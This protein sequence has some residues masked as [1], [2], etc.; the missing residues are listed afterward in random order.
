M[1]GEAKV[2]TGLLQ[3]RALE[4][5][6]AELGRLSDPDAVQR[7]AQTIAEYGSAALQHLLTLLDTPD[8]QLRGGLGQVARK[9]PR[10]QVVPALRGVVRDHGRSDQA[11][12]AAVTLLERFL[13][14]TIDNALIGNLGNPDVA[15]RQSLLELIAAMEEE[16]LSVVEYLEQLGQ[17][18]ADVVSMVLDALPAVDPSPHLATF[19]RMLA[20]GED[21]RVARRAVDELIKLRT[22]AAAR[23]LASLA[24]NLPPTLA[25]VAERGLRKLRFSGVDDA[26]D[27]D[28]TREPW[29]APELNWRALLSPVD[30]GGAQ[31]LWFVGQEEG[32]GKRTVFFTVLTQDPR[33]MVD[34]SGALQAAADRVPSRKRVGALHFIVGDGSAPGVTLLE[35]PL[36]LAYGTLRAALALN[37]AGG[38]ATPIGYRLFAPLVWLSEHAASQDSDEDALAPDLALTAAELVA[39][40]DHPAF[41]GWLGDIDEL[42]ARPAQLASYARRFRA[43]SRWLAASGDADAARLAATLAHHFETATPQLTTILASARLT[44]V[45]RRRPDSQDQ[46]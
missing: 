18:P 6:F 19:L 35:A 14:E 44:A 2:L 16:P 27:H 20:Q 32:A 7:Q 33:G 34:A 37:W 5:A 8:P 36:A 11:R 25:A 30:A 45:R 38:A 46:H 26:A 29:F 41:Y 22:P 31:F 21:G 10:E 1:S 40:L 12:L 28:P 23:A 13:D 39:A 9:L 17:Q 15:A 3:R 43:M 4:Q 42:P 24:P